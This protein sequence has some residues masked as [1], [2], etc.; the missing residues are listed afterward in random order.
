MDEA[1]APT[2]RDVEL[3]ELRLEVQQ[4]RS[5]QGGVAGARRRRGIPWRRIRRWT[6]LVLA[7]ILAILSV[8]MIWVRDTLL[9]TDTWVNTMAPIAASPAVQSAIANDV[10]TQIFE[11]ADVQTRVQDALPPNAAF[12]AA[13]LTNQLR[14]FTTTAAKSFVASD[15]FQ[16]LWN[17][18]NR[19]AHNAVVAV[20]TGEQRGRVSV[21]GG[22]VTLDLS[23]VTSDVQNRLQSSG[24]SAL[25]NV[26][27]GSGQVTLVS[28]PNLVK[29]QKATRVMKGIAFVFPVLALGCLAGAT[30]LSRD[31]RR[32]L[33]TAALGLSVSMLVLLALLAI[34]QNIYLDEVVSPRLPSDAASDIYN[35]VV[36]FVRQSAQVVFAVGV[37]VAAGA[38]LAGPSRFAVATRRTFR[39]GL[40][41]VKESTQARGWDFGPVGIWV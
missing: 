6:L 11:R 38:A 13:P 24:I 29:V 22:K 20:L 16:S 36:H 23:S 39:G 14:S 21:S 40:D 19:R 32:G 25:Q 31:R 28:S 3:E 10:T 17:D 1:N 37:I 4:L 18:L 7:G 2:G 12:L 35:A 34:L 26:N 33:L 5:Q 9:D 30:F 8:L 41:S 15:R 27:L